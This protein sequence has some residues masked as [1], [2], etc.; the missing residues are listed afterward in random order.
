M[1]QLQTNLTNLQS[2]L[3][4]V[5]TLPSYLDTSDATAAASDVAIGQTAYVNG[6]KITG[7]IPISPTT[8]DL[9]ENTLIAADNNLNIY[10]NYD[11]FDER[12]I[13]EPGTFLR[14]T[15]PL[16][17]FGDATAADVL[18]G[19]TFT[20]SDGL[21]VTGTFEIPTC[22]V[23]VTSGNATITQIVYTAF[24]PTN[25]T[26]DSAWLNLDMDNVTLNNCL[27]NSIITLMAD[28]I[29][30][31]Q[32][33]DNCE[34]LFAQGGETVLMATVKITAPNGGTANIILN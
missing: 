33:S 26:I 2:L 9:S 14:Q 5:N 1:S 24:D 17:N 12:T 15:V 7:S 32:A 10:Y 22:T 6:E 31:F 29:S 19:K 3:D 20:S 11:L 8:I 28:D 21:K 18:T 25:K 4:Q 34:F 27:C 13:V 23:N 30:S 16:E